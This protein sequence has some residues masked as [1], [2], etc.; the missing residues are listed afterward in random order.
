MTQFLGTIVNKLDSKGRV[1]VPAG[2]RTAL[3]RLG[4]DLVLRPS[5]SEPCIE[6]WPQAVFDRLAEQ[7]DRLPAFSAEQADLAHSLFARA[8]PCRHDN[9]GRIL[10]PGSLAEHAGLNGA[11]A[12]VGLGRVFQLWDPAAAER[13]TASGAQRARELSLTLPPN[14]EPRA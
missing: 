6:C 14:P 2:F 13:R 8:H 3:E 10:L 12:F 7:L 4:G 1:S 5:H 9:E 11:V